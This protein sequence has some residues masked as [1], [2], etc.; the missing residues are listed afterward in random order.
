MSGCAEQCAV[1]KCL[2]YSLPSSDPAYSPPWRA[3]KEHRGIITMSKRCA[4]CEKAV[5]PLEELKCLDKVS[6][7]LKS[8]RR[9]PRSPSITSPALLWRWSWLWCP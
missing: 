7:H 4:R 8:S 6:P 3:D 1:K 2:E 9:R 5:Y